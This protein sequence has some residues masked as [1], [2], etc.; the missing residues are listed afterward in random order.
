MLKAA[1]V[2]GALAGLAAA[3]LQFAGALKS[4]PP[5]AALPFESSTV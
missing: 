3:A 2:L 1:P 4:A 5:L